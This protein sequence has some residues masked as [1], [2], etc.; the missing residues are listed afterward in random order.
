[1]TRETRTKTNRASTRPRRSKHQKSHLH[2]PRGMISSRVEAAGAGQ[3]GIVSVDCAKSRS[4]WMLCSFFGK[5]LIEPTEVEH[6]KGHLSAAVLQLKQAIKF[7]SLKDVV[8]AIE[9]TG[10]YHEIPRR[11]FTAAGFEVRIVHPLATKQHRLPADPGNK[12]DETDLAAIHRATVNGFGLMDPPLDDV[13]RRLRLLIRQRRGLVEKST[14]LCCQIREHLQLM[15]PGYTQVFSNFWTS[16]VAMPIAQSTGSATAILKAG[17]DGLAGLLKARG[18][19][20]HQRTL[21]KILLWAE[22]SSGDDPDAMLRGRF[23]GELEEDRIAKSLQ[24]QALERDSAGD[25]VKTPYVLLMAIPGL[26]VVSIADFAGEKGPIEH[27]ANDNAITGRAG[28][29]PARYQSDEVDYPDGKLVRCANRRLRAAI[30]RVADNLVCHNRYFAARA[31]LWRT[32]KTDERLIRTRVGKRFCRLAFA[33]V[34]G[35][36]LIPHPCCQNRAY[37]LDKLNSFHQDHGTPMDRRLAELHATMDWLPKREYAYEARPFAEKVEKSQSKTRAYAPRENLAG[38]S[39][40]ADERSNTIQQ[41]R[42]S[43][44]RLANQSQDSKTSL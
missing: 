7:H 14:A 13:S 27:Y 12:T 44:P 40:S 34:G 8:V 32:S 30:L 17:V 28:L 26:N 36:Q 41:F 6:T 19:R 38:H 31:A 11:T 24:I 18:I 1:M 37:I 15:M 22:L 5:V 3:F 33:M 10:N 2:K 16:Q 21:D 29:Y 39:G 4:K 20:F 42:G 43:G 23:L 9:R 25:L 35:R